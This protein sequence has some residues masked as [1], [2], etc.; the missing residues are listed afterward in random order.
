MKEYGQHDTR[1]LFPASMTTKDI[2]DACCFMLQ[3]F[4]SNQGSYTPG[5]QQSAIA[6]M[7]ETLGVKPPRCSATTKAGRQCSKNAVKCGKCGAHLV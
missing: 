7:R 4:D 3:V 5:F 6:V 1:R 2:H